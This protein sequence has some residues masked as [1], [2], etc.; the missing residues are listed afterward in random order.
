VIN[1][2]KKQRRYT[3]LH[4]IILSLDIEKSY[5]AEFEEINH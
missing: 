5:L 3:N 1:I 2:N 4:L